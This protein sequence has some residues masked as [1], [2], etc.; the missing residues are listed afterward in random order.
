MDKIAP[1]L[2]AFILGVIATLFVSSQLK[3]SP[4]VKTIVLPL[5]ITP[6]PSMLQLVNTA[7]EDARVEPLTENEK[8]DRSAKRKACDMAKRDYF[9]HKDPDGLFSWHLFRKAGYNYEFAGENLVQNTS[10]PTE[11]MEMLMDSPEHKENILNPNF[12]E[13]GIGKCGIYLVQHFGS[14][15]KGG[16]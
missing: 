12:K 14:L 5:L 8:L 16:E 9:E 3:K 7:R 15:A 10:T 13:V 1:I 4:E 11:D 6:T 2:L